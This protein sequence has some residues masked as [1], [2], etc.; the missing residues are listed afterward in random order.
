MSFLLRVVL[1]T[2]RARDVKMRV[3]GLVYRLIYRNDTLLRFCKWDL[4]PHYQL[5][6]QFGKGSYTF[7]HLLKVHCIRYAIFENTKAK[8]Q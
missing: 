3:P 4:L 8:R 7:G 5:C 1:V 6:M 2:N